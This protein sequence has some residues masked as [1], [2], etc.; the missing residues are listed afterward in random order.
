MNTY[1]KYATFKRFLG[2]IG[3]LA[4]LLSLSLVLSTCGGG[5]AGGGNNPSPAAEEGPAG[6][7]SFDLIDQALTEGRIDEET[8]LTYKILSLVGHPSLPAEF[9]G[10]DLPG[11]DNVSVLAEMKLKL[12]DPSTLRPETVELLTPIF[13]RPYDSDS[14]F[15]PG[16]ESSVLS[17][18]IQALAV[19]PDCGRFR[20]LDTANGVF[21]IY[22]E[23][24]AQRG[25]AEASV[26]ALDSRVYDSLVSLMGSG[27][28]GPGSPFDDS[29]ESL[30]GTP[31]EQRKYDIFITSRLPHPN[32]SARALTF[33]EDI[34]GRNDGTSYILI[35]ANNNTTGAVPYVVAHELMHAFQYT[36]DIFTTWH[37]YAWLKEATAT[38]AEWHI[39]PDESRQDRHGFAHY[40][41]DP[42]T[43]LHSHESISEA[44]LSDGVNYHPYGA[45]LW[46][47]FL[48][49]TT[50]AG[51]GIVRTI[52]D[53]S[54][55]MNSLAANNA[56]IPGGFQKQFKEFTLQ[57]YNQGPANLY[58]DS[59]SLTWG[60]NEL[61]PEHFSSAT[62]SLT[63]ASLPAATVF[64]L[65][66]AYYNIRPDSQ[67]RFID[68]RLGV[69]N[70]QPG[71]GLK[72]IVR[73]VGETGG[74]VEDWGGL[75]ERIFCRDRP[76]EN[77]E[78]IILILSNS[79][80]DT[81]ATLQ[82]SDI[83]ADI[84][85]SPCFPSGTGT[86]TQKRTY[87]LVAA[88]G[89]KD[90]VT[91][92]VSASF[93]VTYLESQSSPG[94]LLSFA[95]TGS[96]TWSF[97]EISSSIIDYDHTV[98]PPCTYELDPVN[99]GII[100][101]T[102]PNSLVGPGAIPQPVIGFTIGIPA[103]P[104]EICPYTYTHTDPING[105]QTG[106]G[107]M[108]QGGV[109][110]TVLIPDHNSSDYPVPGVFADTFVNDFASFE[111]TKSFT[112]VDG[113]VTTYETHFDFRLPAGQR[114]N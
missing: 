36:Y 111:D 22:Y 5:G 49:N 40:F 87:T 24:E 62:I 85:T 48:S 80:W 101:L 52:W 53:D 71:A 12:R 27:R 113:G 55:S 75:A 110:T 57:N 98:V 6:P 31:E 93:T 59:D 70:A 10:Y 104:G 82:G 50:S 68:F 91:D 108:L 74:H 92:E 102:Y 23:S 17:A 109:A 3:A 96:M 14:Y 112:D 37:D 7:T 13:R 15:Y 29:A 95:A 78:Q 9:K 16:L 30:C 56:A 81:L 42:K 103:I 28:I 83:Q 114:L 60:V 90:Q 94:I 73:R 35:N 89:S 97:E 18:G 4:L 76:T 51:P 69:I 100:G 106:S 26:S 11:A 1:F 39:Y 61:I 105:T 67:V 33:L 32:E 107:N 88:D 72:A 41:L 66:A 25:L 46:P 84:T 79:N 77:I 44:A 65:A 43:W 63:T 99:G 64:P 19:R 86:V 20:V 2:G 54:L 58:R 21:R 47:F 34:L 45:Y 8:A 38:W